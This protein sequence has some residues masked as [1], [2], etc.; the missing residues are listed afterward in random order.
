MAQSNDSLVGQTLSGRYEV[1][2][3]IGEG[4]MGAVY[5]VRQKY[6]QRI[7]A[8]KIILPIYMQDPQFVER[9]LKEAKNAGKVTHPNV[10]VIHDFG[11]T[12]QGALYLAME[13]LEGESLGQTLANHPRGIS[14]KGVLQIAGQV[15]RALEAIH[16]AG[17]VHRDLKPD[18]IM[19]CSRDKG[20]LLVKVLDFGIAKAVQSSRFTQT[21]AIFGTPAYMSPE[22]GRGDPLDARS[23][24]YSLGVILYEMLTGRLPFYAESALGYV[25]KHNQNL[26]PPPREFKQDLPRAVEKAVLKALEKK[27]ANR[28]QTAS[29][30]GDS[31][32]QAINEPPLAAR[33]KKPAAKPIPSTETVLS[34]SRPAAAERRKSFSLA[35]LAGVLGLGLLLAIGIYILLQNYWEAERQRLYN[36]H[37][38]QGDMLFQQEKYPEAKVQ[39][40]AALRQIPGDGSAFGQIE[41]CDQRIA[42]Q[43]RAQ[44][45]QKIAEQNAA[46]KIPPNMVKIPGGWFDMGDTFG[47]GGNDEKRVH[48]VYVNDFYLGQYEV[49]FAEYD[50]FCQAT[51]R[52]KP[53]DQN[54]GRQDRPAINVSWYD[55]V[56]YCNW[57]SRQEGL[58]PCYSGSGDNITCNF[59]ANGYR[60]PTEA[61]W[62]YAAREGGQ[63]VRFGNGKNIANPAEIN[64]N[65]SEAYQKSYSIARVYRKQTVPVNSFSPNRLELYNMSGNVWEW[66]WDWYDGEYYKNSP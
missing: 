12:E 66:C 29:E 58:T 47:D 59:S 65:G 20:A 44:R 42:A 11:E 57:R 3:K 21:G 62:E 46:P 7:E 48:Q 63:K 26:P 56:E 10:V 38:S 14:L 5:K 41:A 43:A 15:C 25:A 16:T 61:E 8:L 4:G 19:L 37:M 13:Y 36:Q 2:E 51:G 49:T 45:D 33:P 52:E 28:F 30:L 27:P 55:A 24:V 60:L 9:F 39:Y 18:N 32:E 54:W 53:S 35:A 6:I 50:A 1:L 34:S 64:F 23:D 22:Q 17:I 31:L 40:Q